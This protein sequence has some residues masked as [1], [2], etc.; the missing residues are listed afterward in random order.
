MSFH[1]NTS[2]LDN[3]VSET[4]ALLQ[5]YDSNGQV[6]SVWIRDRIIR[7]IIPKFKTQET[8]IPHTCLFEVCDRQVKLPCKTSDIIWCDLLD[9]DNETVK[10]SMFMNRATEKKNYVN[11]K[12]FSGYAPDGLYDLFGNTIKFYT[13]NQNGHFVAITFYAFLRDC[14]CGDI[15]VPEDYVE[16]I[17]KFAAAEWLLTTAIE[18]N[19]RLAMV[20]RQDAMNLKGLAKGES[21]KQ[22]EMQK[23]ITDSYQ[24]P[25][26]YNSLYNSTYGSRYINNFVYR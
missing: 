5:S 14:E 20:Y 15:V 26:V 4:L 2:S 6:D 10:F 12:N 18:Q 21:N 23:M 25:L 17:A 1:Y 13:D 16:P 3:L 7:G 9:D 19:T 11:T 8:W 24:R 22:S